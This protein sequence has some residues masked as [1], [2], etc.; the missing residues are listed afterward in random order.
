MSAT[1]NDTAR[2][3]LDLSGDYAA[4]TVHRQTEQYLYHHGKITNWDKLTHHTV[5]SSHIL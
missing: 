3:H 4:H 2:T 5:D 1:C